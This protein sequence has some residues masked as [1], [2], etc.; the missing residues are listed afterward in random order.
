MYRN[1]KKKVSI[2]V[3]FVSFISLSFNV[4][5]AQVEQKFLPIPESVSCIDAEYDLKLGSKDYVLYGNVL[6]LQ[7]F[8]FENGIM[9]HAPTGYFGPITQDS[10]KKYQSL[11][12]LY[13]TGIFDANT[14]KAVAQETCKQEE[15][16]NNTGTVIYNP[17]PN[18]NYPNTTS[19]TTN[20]QIPPTNT[21]NPSYPPQYQQPT[22]N[23]TTLPSN[24]NPYSQTPANP[25]S[26]RQSYYQIT[27]QMLGFNTGFTALNTEN[28]QGGTYFCSIDNKTYQDLTSY[29]RYCVYNSNTSS[30][31]NN[32]STITPPVLTL[33]EV[34]ATAV[35]I[36]WKSIPEATEYK[37]KISGSPEKTTVALGL[38][39]IGLTSGVN[40]TFSIAAVTP[41][42]TSSYTTLPFTTKTARTIF[43]AP[44]NLGYTSIKSLDG[45]S[46]SYQVYWDAVPGATEYSWT[47]TAPGYNTISHTTKNTSAWF[48]PEYEAGKVYTV[49]VRAC[50]ID[51]CSDQFATLSIS[52]PPLIYE[53]S[54]PT[55]TT[56]RVSA[57]KFYVSWSAI[58]SP[59]GNTVRYECKIIPQEN[60]SSAEHNYDWTGCPNIYT[61][62][63]SNTFDLTI[64]TNTVYS[65]GVRAYSVGVGGVRTSEVSLPAYTTVKRDPF[66]Y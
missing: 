31:A 54:T 15:V 61:Y 12:N 11:R 36:R 23:I 62:Q 57:E 5:Q 4:V 13:P 34:G 40:Y 32:L 29:S 39:K 46:Y 18:P 59:A 51:G 58:T 21:Q 33:E 1:F 64:N 17:A 42:G 60:V 19:P 20:T 35:K 63:N 49:T 28:T 37:Y 45:S 2:C 53:L 38:Y 50:D 8:L 65:V 26:D 55:L 52:V 22:T 30:S 6:K 25:T 10:L 27:E 14:R 43:K 44:T 9:Y 7:H 24:Q 3:L 47:T 41:L 48:G 56:S 66:Y 16:V